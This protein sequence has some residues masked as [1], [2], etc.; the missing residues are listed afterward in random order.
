MSSKLILFLSMLAGINLILCLCRS[1][2]SGL[3]LLTETL[4]LD[5]SQMVNS[6]AIALRR[7]GCKIRL[8]VWS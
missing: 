8:L 2:K 6:L 3:L 4:G 7:V 1:M 5:T